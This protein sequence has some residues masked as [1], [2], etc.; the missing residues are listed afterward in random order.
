M[1][2]ILRGLIKGLLIG[3]AIA[4]V[5]SAV[6][7]CDVTANCIQEW[8]GAF[9]GC[10][11]CSEGCAG[12]FGDKG[13]QNCY[14]YASLISAIIGGIYGIIVEKQEQDEYRQ[15]QDAK[16]RA[17]SKEQRIK[18]ASEVKQKALNVTNTCA[19][20]KASDKPLVSTTYKANSQMYD[21]MNEL[22]KA[23]EKQGKVDA[24]AE[25]LS[26]KGGTSV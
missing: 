7:G 11:S 12:Y 17:N 15:A 13:V 20:N 10:G 19:K 3:L 16:E 22:T 2:N 24:L 8:I 1:E 14:L 4:F 25:E 18:W 9:F 6:V 21:I 23:A 26:K 5:L